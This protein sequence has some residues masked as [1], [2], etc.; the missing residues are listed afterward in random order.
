MLKG[1]HTRGHFRTVGLAE[2]TRRMS[3]P[4]GWRQMSSLPTAYRE[5]RILAPSRGVE[6]ESALPAVATTPGANV[7]VLLINLLLLLLN[8]MSGIRYNQSVAAST[9][10]DIIPLLFNALWQT[11]ETKLLTD[12]MTIDV[13]RSQ[14]NRPQRTRY[15]SCDG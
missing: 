9:I 15:T 6:R 2:S 8:V 12:V 1:T 5:T 10:C 11:A 13:N 4:C 3:P 7:N 14:F